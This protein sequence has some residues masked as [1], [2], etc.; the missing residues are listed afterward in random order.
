VGGFPGLTPLGAL[1]LAT[2]CV[3]RIGTVGSFY[4]SRLILC[5]GSA[6]H[7]GVLKGRTTYIQFVGAPV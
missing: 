3:I 2:V 1:D 5:V 6:V 4:L 7:V